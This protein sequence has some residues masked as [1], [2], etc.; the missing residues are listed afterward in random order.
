[1]KKKGFYFSLITL[2]F[3]INTVHAESKFEQIVVT[4]SKRSS[5]IF[6]S[7]KSVEIITQDEIQTYGYRTTDEIL[8][9]SSSISI[10]SN[11]GFGQTK[12]IFLRG[13][14]SNHTKVLLNGVELN[15]GTLGVP[16][17]Q[18]ISPRMISRIEIVKG[19]MSTLYGRDTIGGIINI[20]TKQNDHKL[21]SEISVSSGR[22]NTNGID[23]FKEFSIDSHSFNLNYSD[24]QSDSFKAKV[25]S[26]KDHAYK[27]KN[28][29]LNYNYG[30][31]NAKFSINYYQSDGNTEYDSYGSN[32]S[33]D[34][35]D[36]LIKSSWVEQF[37]DSMTK[38]I[39]IDKEN[40]I[41]QAAPSATDYT[42]TK[43]N[44]LTV[45]K[46]YYNFFETDSIFGFT[47]TDES[48]Y[49]LS[50]GT[51]FRKS[52]DIK[53][54]FFHSEYFP[55]L[56]SNIHFGSRYI[57]HPKYGD[58]LTGTVN[59]GY[60]INKNLHITG[61]IG[62]SF[63]P[64]DGTDL[65]GYGGNENLNPEES[66]S[67]EIFLKYRLPSKNNFTALLFNNDI[68]N[69]IESDGSTMQNINKARITGIE[70]GYSGIFEAI[71]FS[72]DYTYQEADDLTNDTLLSRRP[73]NKMTGKLSYDIDAKNKVGLTIV[74]ESKR[75]NSIY[76]YNRLGGYLLFNLNYLH[77]F[78]DYSIAVRANNLLNKKHR[79]A[80]DYN[81][82]G[83]SI[84]M[85]LI[86]NF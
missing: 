49:E 78:N 26:S 75:D 81:A 25:T 23:F 33:Q 39:F 60:L 24:V 45:E 82:E 38:I 61:G 52:Y 66:V 28:I 69:L 4:P 70:I 67:S 12:S 31:E 80:Y 2:I 21:D 10:G 53:E 46:H 37:N 48:L 47:Y 65:F 83:S 1:M 35:K 44:Q 27:N 42:H 68:S 32:L 34:H 71:N 72:F 7:L 77:K 56:R 64:P 58:Y 51:S 85:S 22:F 62:K 84:Y 30:L 74:G 59:I 40:K 17:I 55:T 9:S 13:T 36:T 18:H 19:S 29:S 20:I 50:Y 79:K 6:E 76:D 43:I 8:D 5:T 14:E 54:L 15:P 57:N 41:D 63:R 16:P 73:R 86:T 11:G 3:A